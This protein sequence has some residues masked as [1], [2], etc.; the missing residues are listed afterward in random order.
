MDQPMTRSRRPSLL[1]KADETEQLSA[2]GN[3]CNLPNHNEYNEQNNNLDRCVSLVGQTLG[4]L[5]TVLRLFIELA[6]IPGIY[7]MGFVHGTFFM[8]R[9]SLSP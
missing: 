6:V 1:Q 7:I 3:A 9:H 8:Q 5:D 4:G 2:A